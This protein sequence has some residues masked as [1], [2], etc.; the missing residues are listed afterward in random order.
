M[1]K[2]TLSIFLAKWHNSQ[3]AVGQLPHKWAVQ[4]LLFLHEKKRWTSRA[5]PNKGMHVKQVEMYII[6]IFRREKKKK[7]GREEERKGNF[8]KYYEEV[9]TKNQLSLASR[10]FL[11][12]T[13][14]Y[15]D[16]RQKPN[17]KTGTKENQ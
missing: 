5:I 14:I 13:A 2:T 8:S 10:L 3:K 7:E 11:K 1:I 9:D 15:W 16:F 4:A 6:I 12:A 17:Q